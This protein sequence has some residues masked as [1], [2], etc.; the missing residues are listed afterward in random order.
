M[1]G[2]RA[3]RLLGICLLLSISSYAAAGDAVAIGYNKDGVWTSIT[4]YSSGT[5]K[6]GSDYKTEAEA[7]KAALRDLRRRGDHQTARAEILSSS[8]DTRFVAVGRGAE[9]SGKDAN[10]VGRGKTQQEADENAM[11]ELRKAGATKNQKVVY[12]YFSNGSDSEKR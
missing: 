12:R 8:N 5:P 4:Y 10:V 7:R 9:A 3:R 2:G 1:S 11:T 6:G